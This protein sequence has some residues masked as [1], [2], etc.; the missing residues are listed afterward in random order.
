MLLFPSDEEATPTKWNPTG[1]AAG[2]KST[3]DDPAFVEAKKDTAPRTNIFALSAEQESQV[4]PGEL[5]FS[6]V[7]PEFVETK[8][9]PMAVAASVVPSADEHSDCQLPVGAPVGCQLT[10]PFVEV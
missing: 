8:V 4:P 9:A 5:V 1:I 2:L 7:I 6:Q 10:A 3:Q